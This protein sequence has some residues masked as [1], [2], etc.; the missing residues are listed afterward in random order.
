MGGTVPERPFARRRVLATALLG[1]TMRDDK[2][3]ARPKPRRRLIQSLAKTV[4]TARLF[5]TCSR[6]AA[7]T[8][9]VN[10]LYLRAVAATLRLGILGIAAAVLVLAD[11]GAQDRPPQERTLRYDVAAVVKLVPVRVL[12]KDG[13]PVT[14][15]R[16]EDF[17]LYEDG[18]RKTITEFE[19]HALTEAGMTVAPELPPGTEAAARRSGAVNRKFF[20][21][22][23]QQAS[24]KAG[25]VKAGTAA[26]RF[27]DTQVRPGDQ[28]AVIGFRAT[29]GFYI[30]E[31]LTE[32]MAKVR[33]AI[34][35]AHEAPPSAAQWIDAP[36]DSV[37]AQARSVGFAFGLA[38][39][40]EVF[41]TIP[42]TK[43]LILFTARDIGV[44]AERLGKLFGAA[45]ITVFAI[46]TQ[47]W[48]LSPM[49]TGKVHFI[50]YDHSLKE[51]AAASG[52]KYF[53]DI[54]DT[55]GIA[56][57]VQNLTGHYYVL[58]HCVRESWE[59]KYHRIR[60]EVARPEAQVLVQD[61][62]LE[63]KPFAQMSDFEKDVHLPDLTWSDQPADSP[64]PLVGSPLPL[65]VDPLVV[66]VEKTARACLLTKWEV[67]V[68]TG[69]P[70]SRVEIFALLRDE[71]GTPLVSRKWETDL[72]R[73]AGR[74][75]FPYFSV[76]VPA[77]AFELQLVV[78]DRETGEASIGRVRFDV[79]AAPEEGVV[80]GSPLL[81][82][83]GTDAVFMRLPMEQ[84]SP[85]R[86]KP[87]V[88]EATLMG[89]YRLIPKAAHPVVGEVTAGARKIVA[90]LPFEIR[91]RQ[92]GEE[93]ILDVAAKLISR[94]GGSETPLEIAV[95]E[96]NTYEGRPDILLAEIS[97]PVLTAGSYELEIA[98]EDIG[99]D[100]RAAVRKPLI[101]R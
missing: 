72:A 55:D 41:K 44:Q 57:D 52:G 91:P 31:Y 14:D 71:A 37:G 33:S 6:R 3:S 13:R 65:A 66:E 49:D 25:K 76:T 59:G 5:S 70:A 45:G 60:V 74:V 48:K 78:R 100:R 11:S 99:T 83:T 64:L 93:P 95:S 94:T 9:K 97:L 46:N 56:Q 22:L 47:D 19:V 82:E 50:W 26:L 42:G 96:L 27:I 101:I 28:V 84:G 87:G 34:K 54:N 17:A 63:S 30:R 29:S 2:G 51:L 24:D 73:Y 35:K 23:D 12:G 7:F 58:G 36:D 80:L 98:I 69:V 61:G 18:Q 86:G 75:L 16:K 8:A 67:G 88:E 39:V 38:E 90:V 32:D 79:A 40:A 77:G 68:R 20:F 53:A 89:L 10:P 43:S 85:A 15:L 4:G 1:A 92:P 81:F 21:L 62:Y